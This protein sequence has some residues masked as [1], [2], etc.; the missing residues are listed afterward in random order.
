MLCEHGID[1]KITIRKQLNADSFCANGNRSHLESA[2]LNLMINA[3][4][5]MPQ[6]GVISVITQTVVLGENSIEQPVSSCG[7]GSYL[8]VSL[9][10]T[11]TGMDSA[12]LS[13][14]FEPFFTT[15]EKGKGTGLGLSRVKECI[16]LHKGHIQ[17]ISELGKGTSIEIYLPLIETIQFPASKKVPACPEGAVSIV[18][19][20]L[21][22][23][24]TYAKTIKTIPIKED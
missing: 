9:S 1:K 16:E 7:P 23:K 18:A 22:C 14:I 13:H 17:V 4:D 15:K 19:E 3:R 21:T 20:V 6:G 5:A 12:V 10:D 24:K 8:H 2:F 11:G